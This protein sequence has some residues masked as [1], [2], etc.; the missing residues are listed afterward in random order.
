[1]DVITLSFAAVGISIIVIV[2]RRLREELSPALIVAATIAILSVLIKLAMPVIEFTKQLAEA[3]GM[4]SYLGVMMKA[5]GIALCSKVCA[6][7][8]RDCGETAI[9]TKVEIGGKVGILLLSIPLL[10]QITNSINSLI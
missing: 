9:A 1:M 6:D 4:S 10:Q 8:C 2:V 7:I 3:Y 5:L